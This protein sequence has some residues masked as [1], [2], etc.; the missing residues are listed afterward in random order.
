[1]FS[2][3]DFSY[4]PRGGNEVAHTCASMPSSSSPSF[5]WVGSLP[6]WLL[7]IAAKDCTNHLNEWS[8]V[9]CPKK[10][11]IEEELS[12]R[13][14]ERAEPTADVG[15]SGDCRCQKQSRSSMVL[16]A[17]IRSV[18]LQKML[19]SIVIQIKGFMKIVFRLFTKWSLFGL[20]D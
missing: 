6:S 12:S 17:N 16:Y 3:V 15:G 8:S 14:R 11:S 1:L 18:I 19:I 7:E 13:R 4:V 2:V 5:S 9:S 20:W 10:R